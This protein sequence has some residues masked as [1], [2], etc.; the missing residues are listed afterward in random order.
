MLKLKSSLFVINGVTATGSALT[1]PTPIAAELHPAPASLRKSLLASLSSGLVSTS[2]LIDNDG[3]W[4]SIRVV[5]ARRKAPGDPPNVS[6][7][8]AESPMGAS[9]FGIGI[10][11]SALPWFVC[12]ANLFEE[13]G[14]SKFS[15]A[16]VRYSEL[17]LL[18][19][20]LLVQQYDGAP[21]FVDNLHRLF[22][23]LWVLMQY[24]T[25]LYIILKV[26]LL[27]S[28][29]A[30]L[31]LVTPCIVIGLAANYAMESRITVLWTEYLSLTIYL[32]TNVA[33]SFELLSMGGER[34]R[35]AYRRHRCVEAHN[36]DASNV[37][38]KNEKV[39]ILV[40]EPFSNV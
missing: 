33:V 24:G 1:V 12:E 36:N 4:R 17:S 9:G 25:N 23:V 28:L 2:V 18:V 22:L 10:V 7:I 3:N 14:L 34:H 15:N 30:K 35:T 20:W 6:T 5:A 8:L 11:L 19:G 31:V 29:V 39:A 21:M 38:T 27:K 13:I 16:A 32:V 40:V 37:V 26:C